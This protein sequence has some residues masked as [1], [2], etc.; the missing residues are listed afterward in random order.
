M[1]SEEHKC[2]EGGAFTGGQGPLCRESLSALP[3]RWMEL[4]RTKVGRDRLGFLESPSPTQDRTLH[5]PLAACLPATHPPTH[6]AL[7]SSGG[8]NPR[9][10]AASPTAPQLPLCYHEGTMLPWG[11]KE[12]ETTV[13]LSSSSS[14]VKE[15]G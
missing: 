14:T 5:P 4:Q 7:P 9:G 11:R 10:Q 12:A 8:T 1:P 3:Q 6:G 13:R 2:G 15:S